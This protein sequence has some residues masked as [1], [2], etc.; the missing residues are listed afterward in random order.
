MPLIVNKEEERKK[1]LASFEECLKEKS[2]FQVSLRDIAKKAHMTHPKL[3]N[4]FQSK[5]DLVIAYC[6]YIKNFM[7]EHCRMW[8][9]NHNP[10]DYNSK[11]DY[12]NAFMKYVQEG[13]EGET[14]PIATVQTYVLAKYNTRVEEMVKNEFKSWRILMKECLESVYGQEAQESDSE[15]MMILIAGV[16]VCQYNQVLTGNIN[17][18]LISASALFQKQN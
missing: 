10:N 8:F 2:I 13:E 17:D 14:R 5:D 6:D 11:T 9:K 15:Y 18:K 3:L 4:Y 16:F 7:S 1:I 12:M